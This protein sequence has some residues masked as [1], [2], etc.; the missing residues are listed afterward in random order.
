MKS[1]AL[2]MWSVSLV[3]LPWETRYSGGLV[4]STK[5]RSRLSATREKRREKM[6]EWIRELYADGERGANDRM[7]RARLGKKDRYRIP[8]REAADVREGGPVAWKYISP[9]VKNMWEK[10]VIT[11]AQMKAAA[12]FVYYFHMGFLMYAPGT[13]LVKMEKVDGGRAGMHTPR[14]GG[15]FPV[16]LLLKVERDVLEAAL[17][18]EVGFKELPASLGDSRITRHRTGRAAFI[19][20]LSAFHRLN[21]TLLTA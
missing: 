12:S 6:Y 18:R 15:S 2:W 9:R 11:T 20:A 5:Y 1:C 3:S 13:N 17:I 21:Q 19:S 14:V 8:V 7:A 16:H 4:L 10:G